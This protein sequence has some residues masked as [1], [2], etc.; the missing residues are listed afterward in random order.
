MTI[1]LTLL[2]TSK[3]LKNLDFVLHNYFIFRLNM[4]KGIL[5]LE[6]TF[7]GK[8]FENNSHKIQVHKIATIK[9]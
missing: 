3:T 8:S 5:E 6:C 9:S 4:N 2:I 7:S 1:N